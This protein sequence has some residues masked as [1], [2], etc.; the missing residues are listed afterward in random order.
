MK[1]EGKYGT[2]QARV[3]YWNGRLTA[4]VMSAKNL[5]PADNPGKIWQVFRKLSPNS[6][7]RIE[8]DVLVRGMDEGKLESTRTEWKTLNPIYDES[9]SWAIDEASCQ[10]PSSVLRFTVRDVDVLSRNDFLGEAIV[11]LCQVKP[12]LQ[13][14]TD[15]DSSTRKW[16]CSYHRL[17]VIYYRYLGSLSKNQNPNP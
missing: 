16:V 2:I 10:L 14:F 8:L 12:F 3:S 5:V 6:D 17:I 9:F 11:P 13:L 15:L 4:E 1:G 7:P